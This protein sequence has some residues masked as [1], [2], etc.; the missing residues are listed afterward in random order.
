MRRWILV[1]LLTASGIPQTREVQFPSDPPQVHLSID[2]RD[3][4]VREGGWFSIPRENWPVRG[5]EDRVMLR[6]H[7]EGWQDEVRESSWNDLGLPQEP[8]VLKPASPGALAQRYPWLMPVGLGLVGGGLL[9]FRRVRRV[10]ARDA[11]LQSLA[12][13]RDPG[14]PLLGSLLGGYRVLEKLG[15]GGMATVYRGSAQG[16]DGKAQQVALK[17]LRPEHADGEFRQRLERERVVSSALRHPHIVTVLGGGEQAGVCY[18]VMELVEGKTLAE[19][20]EPQGFPPRRVRELLEPVVDALD[21][22]HRQ[23]VVHRDLKPGNVLVDSQGKVKVM[24]F[25]LARNQEVQTVTV[26]GMAMGSPG[27]IAPEQLSLASHKANLTPLSDQYAF[28]VMTFELLTGRRPFEGADPMKVVMMHLHDPPPSILDYRPE[29]SE[30][31]DTA[32]QR[33][34]AKQPEQRFPDLRAAGQAVFAALR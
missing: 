28:A 16:P 34:M 19:L 8:V 7:Q 4:A 22:A 26:S 32:L 10:E 31:L 21:Y 30:A 6:F 12:V 25:G 23:G 18:L 11:Q 1:G 29:L 17:V 27:Y 15:S 3:M 9:L 13:V 2:G 33:M 24:D 14:D 5:L 20:L